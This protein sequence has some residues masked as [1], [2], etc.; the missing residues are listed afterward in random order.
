MKRFR[1]KLRAL[2]RRRQL[3]RDLEDELRFHLE[4]AAQG[5]GCDPRPK[6]GNP[7]G[8]AE[9]CRELWIFGTLETWWQDVRYAARTL[10]RN[11]GFAAIAVIALGLGIGA[12]TAI[13]TIV[14]GAI[15]WDMGIDHPDRVVIVNAVDAAHS[16]NFGAS[17][18]EFRELQPRVKSLEGLAAYLFTPVNV[19][20]HSGLPQRYYCV[21]LSANGNRVAHQKP[22][23]GRDFRPED[24]QPG[25]APVML[26]GHHVW[27]QRYGGDPAIVG[28]AIRV[29]EVPTVV[30]GVMPPER[31]FPEDT[32][33]WT[34]LVPT[35]ALEKR[36]NRELAIYGRLRDGVPLGAAR[37]ELDTLMRQIAAAHPEA[38]TGITAEVVPVIVIT[39]AYGMRPLLV[40]LFG[41]V[42]FVLLI[43][44][45]DVANMLLA[46]AAGRA[47]EISIRVAIGAGR[48]RILRQL[49][50]ESTLLSLAGGALGWLVAMG[51]LRWFEAGTG[52]AVRPPW[53]HLSLDATAYAY[54]AAIS[55]AT[56]V[57][58][59]LAPALRLAKTDIHG[60]LKD[61]GHGA[62]GGRHNLRL[63]RTLVAFEMTLC[64]MLLAAAG[65]MIRSLANLYA[66]PV[67]ANT[68]NVLTMRV[69]LPES[70][71]PRD[72]DVLR[73]HKSLAK[74]LEALPGVDAAALASNVPLG[75]WIS[76]PYQREGDAPQ[77]DHL[78][79]LGAIVAGEGYFRVM[80]IAPRRGRL[81]TSADGESGNPVTLV[82][83]S[84]AAKVW[85]DAD[86]LGKR[87]RLVRRGVPQP[88]LTVVGVVPDILQ[89][90]RHPLDHAALIYL[91]HAEAPQREAYLVARTVVPP[92]TLAQAFRTAVQQEDE[93]LPAY[94][95]RSLDSRFAQNRL[96]NSL[97][98]AICTIFAAVALVLASIG[99]YS[100]TS[101]AVSRRMQEFGIRIAMGSSS[102]DILRL[103]MQQSLRPL[104][105]GLAI[106]LPLALGMTRFLR[107]L[108]AGVSPGDP[109]TF[110]AATAVLVAAGVAGCAIPAHRAVRV[111]PVVVLRCE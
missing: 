26:L 108:L 71:Y 16:Q 8:I 99:L 57:L 21:Q 61:G 90:A 37:V 70:K 79:R 83:A 12:D 89:D 27:Q 17:Y 5:S 1:K 45:A 34:N 53:L 68:A 25:A 44:C 101:H 93:S 29:N 52:G 69:A 32:D 103:V 87:L 51:G 59:G 11:P 56:G 33:L 54:L 24:E 41:A 31:R 46:R 10:A 105:Y 65:L 98:G 22:L 48:A 50:I 7:A 60:A 106:G 39:G 49:L 92:A 91:P 78:P 109:L 2:W 9:R 86:P 15:S 40:V 47:R 111:D 23:L 28:R 55:L 75:G 13:F 104:L 42:G 107:A 102:G 73:F 66:T 14:S 6:F 81:F 38:G 74:R 43:A 3:D 30:I 18:P 62:A 96:T 110:F 58:F 97:F 77:A 20:D 72:E 82:N 64:V 95:V 94:E 4:M 84:F 19:S 100:V 76:I 67:G 80:Q 88:W 63:A 35:A 85:P 36:E